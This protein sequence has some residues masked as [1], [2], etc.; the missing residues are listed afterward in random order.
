[1]GKADIK[2]LPTPMDTFLFLIHET[3]ICF[4]LRIQQHLCWLQYF[5]FMSDAAPYLSLQKLS[6]LPPGIE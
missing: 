2:M 3:G 1:L 4:S 6:F 5:L